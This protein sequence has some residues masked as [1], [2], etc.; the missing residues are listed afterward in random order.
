MAAF[1]EAHAPSMLASLNA[2]FARHAARPET[3]W[4]AIARR[5]PA[6]A[7]E[8]F[9]LDVIALQ[10]ARMEGRARLSALIAAAG[11]SENTMLEWRIRSA[12][13]SS[14]PSG[15]TPAHSVAQ[16]SD[17]VS[18][19]PPASSS[20]STHAYMAE[21]A[22]GGGDAAAE[23]Q[24]Q[25][26]QSS[27]THEAA[28]AAEA[29]NGHVAVSP[30]HTADA[31]AEKHTSAAAAAAAAVASSS[32]SPPPS[33]R[34][35]VSSRRASQSYDTTLELKEGAL[36]KLVSTPGVHVSVESTYVEP[37]GLY[38]S[39][40]G[41]VLSVPHTAADSSGSHAP[42]GE[43]EEVDVPPGATLV[44]LTRDVAPLPDLLEAT[45]QL[46]ALTV[47]QMDALTLVKETHPALLVSHGVLCVLLGVSPNW[48]SALSAIVDPLL[49]E[50]LVYLS[51]LDVS[52]PTGAVDGQQQH[53]EQQHDD[54]EHR[55]DGSDTS[56]TFEERPTTAGVTFA[57]TALHSASS[58]RQTE[59]ATAVL[60]ARNTFDL[61]QL[62]KKYAHVQLSARTVTVCRRLLNRRPDIRAEVR[63]M[64]LAIKSSDGGG[65]K[66]APL[67]A[68]QKLVDWEVALVLKASAQQKAAMLAASERKQKQAAEQHAA[69]ALAQQQ[70]LVS[71]KQQQ[72]EVGDG[73]AVQQQQQQQEVA[74]YPVDE[75]PALPQ[76][77]QHQS[78][79]S[80]VW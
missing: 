48:R 23:H 70:Q 15:A 55:G 77:D 11:L 73:G 76:T 32:Q 66:H 7:C 20:S 22:V 79:V 59:G 75:A 12:L 69:K 33:L 60:S 74:S 34:L 47:D 6:S 72:Q 38:I 25:H 71:P 5:F 67:I 3:L 52:M 40:T 4:R 27:V 10:E 1:A 26:Q 50:K 39:R 29:V 41:Q 43:A 21:P 49:L 2:A 63:C 65:V 53:G 14:S 57:G 64:R 56:G 42:E 51:T 46:Q 54:F 9:F 17:G 37:P 78:H 30:G 28:V 45:R 36:K 24:Q 62:K 44:C 18:V 16:S 61:E 80:L 31:H 8:P 58:A 13:L 68:L 35:G 19:T